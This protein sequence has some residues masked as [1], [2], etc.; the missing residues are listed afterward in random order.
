MGQKIQDHSHKIGKKSCKASYSVC[1][2]NYI[3]PN[4]IPII[5]HNLT[6]YDFLFIKQL[7]FHSDE[8]ETI[9]KNKEKYI[10]FTKNCICMII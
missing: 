2:L 10:S 6:G 1:N 9:A 8:I 5:L 4:S 7:C 3:E